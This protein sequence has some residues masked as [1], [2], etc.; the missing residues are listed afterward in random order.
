MRVLKFIIIAVVIIAV[1]WSLKVILS[2]KPKKSIGLSSIREKNKE[3]LTEQMRQFTITGFTDS[4]NKAWELNANTADILADIVN[5]STIKGTSFG[6]DVKVELTSVKGVFNRSSSNILLKEEVIIKSDEGTVLLTDSLNWSAKEEIV[7]TDDFVF[8]NRK[9][10][11]VSGKGAWAKPNLKVAN[12]LKEVTLVVKDPPAVITC[13]G[14]LEMDYYKN[15]AYFNNKVHVVDKETVIDADK[16]TA[17]FD[18]KKR[19]LVKVLCVGNVEITRGED[20]TFADS[21][22]YLPEE[23][24]VVLKGRPKIIIDSSGDLLNEVKDSSEKELS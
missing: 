7:T 3:S 24:R 2:D 21:L 10:M 18:P 9:D 1:L 14:P 16:A 12:I 15:V 13:D 4:G 17:Y 6:D 23:G 19:S 11:D 5:L 22:T 20:K 8:I